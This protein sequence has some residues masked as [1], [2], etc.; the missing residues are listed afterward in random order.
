MLYEN[1]KLDE[2]AVA[3]ALGKGQ[4]AFVIVA[5]GILAGVPQT[6]VKKAVALQNAKAIVALAWKAGFSMRLAAR[7]QMQ[8]A[9]IPPSGVLRASGTDSYPLSAEEM[10]WQ[11]EFVAGMSA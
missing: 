2:K 8:I 11:L 4:K 3:K 6:V 1:G 7:L 10:N 5:L 9:S